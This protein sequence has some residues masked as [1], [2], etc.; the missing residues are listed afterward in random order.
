MKVNLRLEDC[1]AKR[2][3]QGVIYLGPST[4]AQSI[5]F[6]KLF[7]NK[8]LDRHN[9]PVDERLKQIKGKCVMRVFENDKMIKEV[10]LKEGQELIISATQF[11][12]HTNR[13]EKESLTYWQF[14]GNI[15]E[16]IENIRKSKS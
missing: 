11:H 15:I 7:P 13:F 12:Q 8:S 5:G 4:P 14:N 9:R 6:L 1:E 16:I 10:E 2:L 3:P